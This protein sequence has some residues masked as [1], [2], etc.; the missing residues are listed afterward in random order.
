MMSFA[1]GAAL[2]QEFVLL[3]LFRCVFRMASS[4]Q[5]STASAQIVAYVSNAAQATQQT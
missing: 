4:Y 5:K 1:L 2:V 3:K